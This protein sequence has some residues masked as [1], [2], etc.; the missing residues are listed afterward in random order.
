MTK[1]DELDG[2][3]GQAAREPIGD[4]LASVP[5]GVLGP[6]DVDPMAPDEPTDALVT[7]TRR[8]LLRLSIVATEVGARF[9]SEGIGHDPAAWMLTPRDA[10]DGARAID[11]CQDLRGFERAVLLHGLGFGLDAD[12]CMLDSLLDDDDDHVDPAAG[13][14]ATFH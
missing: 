8:R 4:V 9:T 6:W 12:P 2:A 5:T 10:F 11:A 1:L 7:T 3:L 13:T 14:D